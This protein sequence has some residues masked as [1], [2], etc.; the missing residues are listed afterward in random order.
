MSGVRKALMAVSVVLLLDACN[1]TG[2]VGKLFQPDP[3]EQKLSSGMKSYED[4]D[5]KASQ[6]ALQG[7][8][9]MGLKS[10]DEQVQAHKYLAFIH[11]ASGQEEQC[12]D[13]F[14][15][16]LDIDPAFDLKPAEAG[17]PIWG[18]VFRSVKEKYAK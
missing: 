2:P 17:H 7:A 10:K 11:C 8:L 18:P 15:K 5:Y 13:E 12:R 16:A 14:R 1:A 3:A 9:G 6:K 4:G